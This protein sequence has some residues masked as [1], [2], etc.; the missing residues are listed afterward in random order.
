MPFL[1]FS[2]DRRGYESTYLVQPERQRA[3]DDQ[4]RLLYWFR[5]PPHVKVGRAAFDEDAIRLLEEAHPNLDFDWDRI[6]TTRPPA[7]PE[8]E[9][10][11]QH[12]PERRGPREA[13][14]TEPRRSP[15]RPEPRS[16]VS[17]GPAQAVIPPQAA[18]SPTAPDAMAPPAASPEAPPV[19]V[20]AP[21]IVPSAV[22]SPP[23]ATK[24]RFVR[25]FDVTAD[26]PEHHAS[27]V[28]VVERMLGAEQLTILRARYAEILARIAAR[29]GDALRILALR[30]QAERANPDAWVTEAEVTA[31]LASVDATLAELHHLVGRRR[32]RRRRRRDTGAPPPAGAEAG[33]APGPELAADDG[34]ED[35]GEEDEPAEGQDE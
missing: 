10:A 30:E 14:R 11:R 31:G 26:A 27:E 24:R 22:P 29:G 5:T 6:L 7:A 19:I 28:A 9:D 20:T 4:P 32:R 35:A 1:R 8:P 15:A 17:A 18:T 3:G 25:V 23:P 33:A 16:P 21:P 34:E 13:R 12:R 2:R